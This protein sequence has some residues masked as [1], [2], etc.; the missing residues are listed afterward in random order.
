MEYISQYLQPTCEHSPDSLD[1]SI[2]I[3]SS[4]QLL[5][6]QARQADD[7]YG[8]LSG[9]GHHKI[10]YCPEGVPVEQA[11]FG[12]LAAFAASFGL[13]FRAVSLAGRK[14]RRKRAVNETHQQYQQ[15]LAAE[16]E[17]WLQE[18]MAMLSDL[19]WW[20]RLRHVLGA[21]KTQINFTKRDK[22]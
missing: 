5:A 8:A 20:G 10:I 4:S 6:R 7:S 11:I 14:R 13:L 2:S 12:L 3:S 16:E 15:Y 22:Y 1:D 18:L 9:Y 17:G 21:A 19:Y